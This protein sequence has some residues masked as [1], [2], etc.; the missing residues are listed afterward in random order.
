MPR[1]VTRPPTAEGPTPSRS[2]SPVPGSALS[3]ESTVLP[4]EAEQIFLARLAWINRASVTL[5]AARYSLDSDDQQE[6]AAIVREKLMDDHYA[7]IRK[8]RGEASL[9]TYLTTVIANQFKDYCVQ[10][11]GRWR[12]SAAARRGGKDAVRLEGLIHRDGYPVDQAIEVMRSAGVTLSA[13]ELRRL[14][15]S[16]PPRVNARKH[17]KRVPLDAAATDQAEDRLLE[18]ER[19]TVHEKAIAAVNEA[20]AKLDPMDQLILRLRIWENLSV[21]DIARA[22]NLEQKPLY[23]R[24][25]RCY[26]QLKEILESNGVDADT[27]RELLD[28]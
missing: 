28:G 15:M 23:R 21:A 5:A 25:E 27:V 26:K 17:D 3:D 9:E 20:L 12:P 8:H 11:W 1:L 19:Q 4:S 10:R 22:Q 7:A 2:V 18:G 14:A 24:I 6:F 13:S 16:F